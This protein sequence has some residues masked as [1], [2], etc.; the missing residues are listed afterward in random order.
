M[1]KLKKFT[2]VSPIYHVTCHEYTIIDKFKV[3]TQEIQVL[4]SV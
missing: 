3:I 2:G 4:I 1:V